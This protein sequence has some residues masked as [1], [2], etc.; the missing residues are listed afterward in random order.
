MDDALTLISTRAKLIS[1]AAIRRYNN[2]R[3][4]RNIEGG[5]ESGQLGA[6][7]VR[8]D[9]SVA[10]GYALNAVNRRSVLR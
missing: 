9:D 8:N 10:A 3:L 1:K 2:T 4:P 6:R 7:N 5:V